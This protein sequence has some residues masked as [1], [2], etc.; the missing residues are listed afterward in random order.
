MKLTI[1]MLA[2]TFEREDVFGDRLSLQ[3]YAGKHLLLSFF[4]N[5]ACAMCNLQ[6]HRMIEK[7]PLYHSQ[8]LEM[9]AVFESPRESVLQYVSRQNAPFPIIADPQAALYELY[10]VESSEEKV[11]APV[12]MDWR[13][14]LIQE[15]K[16]IGFDLIK[17]EGSN[18]FRMPADFLIAPDQR[19]SATFYSEAVGKHLP[20]EEIEKFLAQPA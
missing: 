17:E 14:Q 9:I 12:D 7:Y 19:L 15:A 13:N 3:A 4:R 10:G 16:D 6:V 11:M 1:G 8:G 5:G 2:P 20:F 18:F